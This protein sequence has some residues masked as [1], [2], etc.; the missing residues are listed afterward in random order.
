MPV[1][2]PLLYKCF[3][4]RHMGTLSYKPV[5]GY[6]LQLTSCTAVVLIHNRGSVFNHNTQLRTHTHTS[7]RNI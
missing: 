5:G 4:V 3:P 7:R 2:I 1:F 6:V